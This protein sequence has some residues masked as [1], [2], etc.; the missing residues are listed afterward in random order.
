M[1]KMEEKRNEAPVEKISIGAERQRRYRAVRKLRSEPTEERLWEVL[2]LYSGVCFKTYSGLTFTYEIRKG[3]NG[4]YTKEL[5]ID[6]RE[7]SKSLAWSSALLALRNIKNV[8]EVVD[9]PKAL[10]DIRG[11]TYIYGMFYRFGLIDIPGEVKGKMK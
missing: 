11:V 6:R 1:N 9:R 2:L 5:W 7:K 3:R 4:Q 8:G 10:G